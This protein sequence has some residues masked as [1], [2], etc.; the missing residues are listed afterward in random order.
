MTAGARL[1]AQVAPGRAKEWVQRRVE[2][3]SFVDDRTIHRETTVQ[4]DA[5]RV[6]LI[7]L[8]WISTTAALV[9]LALLQRHPHR[10]LTV[11]DEAGHEQSRLTR[12]EE[13][14]LVAD[15]VVRLLH[16]LA[17][18]ELRPFVPAHA[19]EQETRSVL[20]SVEFEQDTYSGRR[21]AVRL[22][23]EDLASRSG[24]IEGYHPF[25][26]TLILLLEN[27]ILTV[28]I[29]LPR[30]SRRTCKYTYTEEL[31]PLTKTV[32]RRITRFLVGAAAGPVSFSTPSAGEAENYLLEIL[33]PSDFEIVDTELIV[34]TSGGRLRRVDDLATN[35][36]AHISL[37]NSAV[38]A[39]GAAAAA[40]H[41]YSSVTGAE[42]TAAVSAT[43]VALTLALTRYHLSTHHWDMAQAFDRSAATTAAILVPGAIATLLVRDAE[44]RKVAEILFP[45]RFFLSLAALCSYV[46][47]VAVSANLATSSLHTIWNGATLV[48]TVAS[49][50]L[51][52]LLALQTWR[53]SARRQRFRTWC[54]KRRGLI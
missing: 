26:Q 44:H 18:K 46:C 45:L 13:R 21:E 47:A 22:R 11:T 39:T 10:S 12:G 43:V 3:V 30:R 17:S 42:R 14:C 41:L 4:F 51:W 28:L 53:L 31:P 25:R 9:P 24:L 35:S 23:A 1:I 50:R 54:L 29:E 40:A 52:E 33:P 7:H 36:S 37:D 8:P 20:T 27:Y 16:S 34:E 2:S 19:F 5:G 15:G 49:L 48:A 32:P 38:M 6:E